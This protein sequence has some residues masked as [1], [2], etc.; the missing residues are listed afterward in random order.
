[1]MGAQPAYLEAAAALPYLTIGAKLASEPLESLRRFQS[2]V[3]ND[4]DHLAV[5]WVWG[6]KERIWAP[7]I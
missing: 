2:L 5:F 3:V 1:M 7:G 6:E 4:T